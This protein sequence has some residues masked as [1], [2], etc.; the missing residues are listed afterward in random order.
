MIQVV[1]AD[2]HPIIREGLER[3]IQTVEDVSLLGVASDYTSLQALLADVTPDVVVI[4]YSMPGLSGVASVGQFIERGHKIVMFSFLER[5]EVLRSLV[6]VGISGFV[7]KSQPVSELLKVV[8]AVA[9]GERVL[10]SWQDSEPR[11]HERL[12]ERERWVLDRVLLGQTPKEMAF[13]LE[14]ATSSVY[15]Y[16]ERIRKKLGVDSTQGLIQYAHRVGLVDGEPT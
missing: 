3:W 16:V 2:D 4:D 9:Q 15:T 5:D 12:S 1:L 6:E 10:P 7:S 13:E 14:V 8:R 11:P